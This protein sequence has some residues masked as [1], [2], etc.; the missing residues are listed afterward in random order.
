MEDVKLDLGY[1][2]D[3]LLKRSWNFMGRPKLVWCP[4]QLRL[5]NHY[6]IYHVGRLQNVEINID[7]IKSKEYF[8]VI[9]IVDEI[10]PYE[11]L[12]GID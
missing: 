8:E 3:I 7:G 9:D 4:I 6:R 10:D 11:K 5:A 2:M 1:D 12:L